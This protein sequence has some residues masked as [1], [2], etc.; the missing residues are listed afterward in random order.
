MSRLAIVLA[1]AVVGAWAG[2]TPVDRAPRMS[3]LR[4]LLQ[5]DRGDLWKVPSA[6]ELEKLVGA[7]EFRELE[8]LEKPMKQRTRRSSEEEEETMQDCK[9]TGLSSECCAFKFQAR[10]GELKVPR[11]VIERHCCGDGFETPE[12]EECDL[13][14]P[15]YSGSGIALL[16]DEK[17]RCVEGCTFSS[18]FFCRV[19]CASYSKR[20]CTESC[21]KDCSLEKSSSK[22]AAGWC[23]DP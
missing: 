10:R 5:M 14:A 7:H 6:R 16:T 11:H 15:V 18:A 8:T 1:C 21:Q 4:G 2:E 17:L 12:L 19:F 22:I 23:E 3:K 9:A 20:V 13:T